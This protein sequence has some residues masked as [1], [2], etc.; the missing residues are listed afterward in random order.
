MCGRASLT[1]SPEQI[2][3]AF[4]LDEPPAAF[5][6]RYNIAPTQPILAVLPRLQG[7]RGARW[8]RWGLVR[9]AKDALGRAPINLKVESAAKGALRSDLRERRCVVPFTGF[10]EWQRSGKHRQ[11]YNLQR[12]DG[13][14]LGIA[15]V[16]HRLEAPGGEPLETCL[17]LTTA[18]VGPAAA[19]H[20]R[21]PLILDP[22]SYGAWLDPT[23]REPADVLARVRSLA[24]EGLEAYPVSPLVNR[25]SV[26][27]PRCLEPTR[28]TS[29]W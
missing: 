9:S 22:A 5:A 29:L 25:A 14:P 26:D 2:A 13:L 19:I 16:W 7:G 6:P 20:D 10:Y 28:A 27:E 18:A 12:R 21:M 17:V 4:E 11:P 1:A 23:P 8:L 24:P 15:G 3:E